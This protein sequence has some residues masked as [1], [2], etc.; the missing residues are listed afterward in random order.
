MG[1]SRRK[2]RSAEKVLATSVRG[3]HDLWF[4]GDLGHKAVDTAPDAR[5][6][7]KSVALL[8]ARVCL[9]LLRLRLTH[10]NLFPDASNQATNL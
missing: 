10:A 1:F 6:A 3:G 8:S 9:A 7:S 4:L 2:T 5:R